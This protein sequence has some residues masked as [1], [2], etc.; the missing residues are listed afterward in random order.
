MRQGEAELMGEHAYLSPVMSFVRQHVAEHFW[1][2]R[3]RLRPAIAY[4][5]AVAAVPG[6][7]RLDEHLF[8]ASGACGQP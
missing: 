3:P 6:G 5:Q 8:A 4:E 1:T 2:H 7:E